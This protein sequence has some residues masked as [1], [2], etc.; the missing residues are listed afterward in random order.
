V[1]AA[2]GCT[3]IDYDLLRAHV[4]A[5]DGEGRVVDL[6]SGEALDD[7]QVKQ[8]SRQLLLV[9][10]LETHA[11]EVKGGRRELMIH[12]HGGLNAATSSL[13]TAEKAVRRMRDDPDAPHPIFIT[14]PSGAWSTYADHLV[15]VRQGERWP[16]WLGWPTAPF[17]LATD[18]LRSVA[19]AP[20]TLIQQWFLDAQVAG[21]VAFDADLRRSMHDEQ[22]LVPAAVAEGF[23]VDRGDYE[24][25]FWN[26]AGRFVS[27]W[28]SQP[29]KVVFQVLVLNGLGQGAWEMMLR[30]TRSLFHSPDEFDLSKPELTDPEA[31]RRHVRGE[32][33]RL[34]VF[35]GELHDQTCGPD[36]PPAHHCWEITLV[37][38]SMGAFVI[39]EVLANY[40]DLPVKNIVYMAPACSVRDAEKVI[41]PYLKRHPGCRFFLLTLHPIAEADEMYG[42]L[43][44]Y[45]VLPRGSLLEWIDNWYTD[46][47]SHLDRV[48][49]KWLNVIPAIQVFFD[50]RDRVFI[51]SFDV[52]SGSQPQ[53]HGDFNAFAFWHPAFWWDAGL[54]R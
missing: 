12:I 27:Y 48:L 45:D 15:G 28:L 31:P 21:K 42:V 8:L 30:R 16:W 44:G 47:P 3:S 41:V 14:W 4:L 6:V 38:H 5:A 26:Q 19:L 35:F 37:G 54:E 43:P 53:K 20:R 33:K 9:A 52:G 24:R 40:P 10:Q 39:N 34:H 2:A 36:A 23:H 51:K 17:I 49:G 22:Y 1:A 18:L 11:Q 7:E 13:T 50:V 25:G 46:P 32:K 29:P